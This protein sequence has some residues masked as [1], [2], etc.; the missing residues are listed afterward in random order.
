MKLQAYLHLEPVLVYGCLPSKGPVVFDHQGVHG[1]KHHLK[2]ADGRSIVEELT[3]RVQPAPPTMP[4]MLQIPTIDSR[5]SYIRLCRLH[6]GMHSVLL[7]LLLVAD[8]AAHITVDL[9][10]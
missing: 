9:P 3:Y 7:L 8:T 2:G 1:N 5:G 6:S 10:C 4:S